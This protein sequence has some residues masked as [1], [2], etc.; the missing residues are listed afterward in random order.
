MVRKRCHGFDFL[1]TGKIF[2]RPPENNARTEVSRLNIQRPS[3]ILR[4]GA[5]NRRMPEKQGVCGRSRH[6]GAIF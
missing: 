6:N 4:I 1:S 5:K 2:K 3:G